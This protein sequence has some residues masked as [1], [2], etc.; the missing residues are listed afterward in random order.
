[1]RKIIPAHHWTTNKYILHAIDNKILQNLSI[2][3]EDVEMAEDIYGPSVPHFQGKTVHHSIHNMEPVM[4][5]SVPRPPL[6]N[7]IKS[8]YTVTSYK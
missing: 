8:P 2:L 7:K 6:T 5:Q 1:M 4:V 3:R